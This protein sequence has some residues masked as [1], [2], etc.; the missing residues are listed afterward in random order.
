MSFKHEQSDGLIP[1]KQTP[2]ATK[3][4]GTTAD[5][6]DEVHA[7][8][9]TGVTTLTA[10]T[11]SGTTVGA[12]TAAYVAGRTVA[13]MVLITDNIE[14]SGK[15]FTHGLGNQYPYMQVYDGNGSGLPV[16]SGTSGWVSGLYI[17]T[18]EAVSANTMAI[19]PSAAISGITIRFMG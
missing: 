16:G 12:G 14:A 5:K 10:T 19:F 15:V 9:I 4:L 2:P 13:S 3:Q 17:E 8:T 11:V 18:M 7:T 6:W 1:N